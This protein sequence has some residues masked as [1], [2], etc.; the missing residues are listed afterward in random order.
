MKQHEEAN[1][2]E[3]QVIKWRKLSETYQLTLKEVKEQKDPWKYDNP[4]YKKLLVG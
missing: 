3:E 4:E 2:K 1:E